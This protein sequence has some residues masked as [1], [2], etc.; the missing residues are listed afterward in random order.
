LGRQIVQL[1]KNELL[2]LDLRQLAFKPDKQG[3]IIQQISIKPT[4]LS[5]KTLPKPMPKPKNEVLIGYQ[6]AFE[7]TISGTLTD[8]SGEALIGASILIKGTNIGTI[9]DI[10]GS[11][12]LNVPNSNY[13]LVFSYTGY[14]T[15]EVVLTPNS[16]TVHAVLSEGLELL[17]VVVTGYGTRKREKVNEAPASISVLSGK[18]A[19][20]QISESK[21]Q[22]RLSLLN[23][24][25]PATN[26]LRTNFKDNAF[27]QPNLVTDRNGEA[28]FTTVFPDNLTQWQTFVIGMDKKQRAGISFASTNA[29]KPLIAQLAIPR[30]LI[31]ADEANIIGKAINFT[32]DSLSV[33]TLFKVNGKLSKTNS[34]TIAD[35]LIEKHQ[36]IA[37]TQK[38]SVTINYQLKNGLYGDGEQRQIPIFPKGILEHKGQ[39]HL[40]ETDT[41]LLLDFPDKNLPITV[42]IEGNL[43]NLLMENVDYLINYPHGCNE[44]TASKLQALLLAKKLKKLQGKPF[45]KEDYIQKGIQRLDK[46][47]NEIGSWGWW[48][49]DR[50][51]IWMTVYVLKALHAA[52]KM[53]YPSKSLNNGLLFLTNNLVNFQE[54][55]LLNTL[56]LFADIEQKGDF[57][58]WV[59]KLDTSKN[60]K[61]LNEKL[62]LLKIKQAYDLPHT[63]DTLYKYQQQD[64]FGNSF[65]GNSAYHWYNTDIQNSLLAFEILK[66]AGKTK[67]CQGITRYILRQRGQN[68]WLNTYRTAKTLAIL[69]ADDIATAKK[70]TANTLTITGAKKQMIDKFP[71]QQTFGNG[72]AIRLDKTG[73]A[74]L[75]VTAYQTFWNKNPQPKSDIF[76]VHSILKQAGQKVTN[77]TATVPATL[78]VQLEVKRKA[79]YVMIEIPI[80]AGCSYGTKTQPVSWYRN[81]GRYQKNQ[82]VHREYFKEKVAI[83]CREL[84][85]GKYTYTINLAPRFTGKYTLKRRFFSPKYNFPTSSYLSII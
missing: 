38:D 24:N 29:F 63:L 6:D 74:P 20:V 59:T 71:F 13:T 75:Y 70:P 14:A 85:Q 44:Q 56:E 51:N 57:Q 39:F 5:K 9:T 73:N 19:G 79:A 45:L 49:G 12:T 72:Q 8:D 55:D 52:E 50:Q 1:V 10:D 69:L 61:N 82:E 35:A 60:I 32:E 11:Y 64:V 81:G 46:A 23:K 47:Q 15:Q 43:R 42:R 66:K 65:W 26:Q 21:K 3:E 36:L 58:P 41:T 34:A 27:W 28:Y 68:G 83:Y 76:E 77:L 84:P 17:E 40:L 30:F 54:R 25:L 22:K 31:A 48:T 16:E 37:A 2:F 53:G 67:I 78:E 62:T 4:E 80:P 33:N 18:I 7:P